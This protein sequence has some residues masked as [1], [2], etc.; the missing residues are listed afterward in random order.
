M[1]EC[2]K[3]CGLL[4][5]NSH[6]LKECSWAKEVWSKLIGDSHIPLY[7]SVRE[8]IG[9]LLEQHHNQVELFAVGA[10]Q[11]WSA[12]NDLVFEKIT[13]VPDLCVKRTHDILNEFKKACVD[14]PYLKQRRDAS[15]WISPPRSVIKV[16]VDAAVN[17]T[18]DRIGLGMVARDDNGRVVLAASKS[19]WPFMGVERAELEAF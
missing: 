6:V 3:R 2:C 14:N 17:A 8:W 7:I 16:N 10:W 11:I 18:D 1:V 12:R 5:T 9:T 19:E 4:E 13:T 15:K